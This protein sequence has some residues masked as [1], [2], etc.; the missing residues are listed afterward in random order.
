MFT[1]PSIWNL[2][3][4]TVVF[5]IATGFLRRYLAEQGLPKGTTRGIL[6]FTLASLVSCGAGEMVDWGQEKIEGPQPVKQAPDDLSQLLK[7]VGQMQRQN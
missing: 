6:V 2:L 5:F 7:A 4:S 3:I 1:L